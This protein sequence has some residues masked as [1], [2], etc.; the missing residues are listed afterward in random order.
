[1]TLSALR[2]LGVSSD[3]HAHRLACSSLIERLRRKPLK[4]DDVSIGAERPVEK[5][6]ENCNR[7]I[8]EVLPEEFDRSTEGAIHFQN[9]D[10]VLKHVERTQRPLQP[11]L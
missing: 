8:L 6:Q 5:K 1:M 9:A 4:T 11:V 2:P 3:L 10:Q 7:S